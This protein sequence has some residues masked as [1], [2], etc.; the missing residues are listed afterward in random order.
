MTKDKKGKYIFETGDQ[1][2]IKGK[3][4]Y[5]CQIG[6]NQYMLICN[7]NRWADTGGPATVEGFRE[8]LGN[9][10]RDW[11]EIYKTRVP[12]SRRHLYSMD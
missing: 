5:L 6:T 10:S 2:T 8:M 7:Y 9:Y 12:I 1:Y 3:V 4:C 11:E